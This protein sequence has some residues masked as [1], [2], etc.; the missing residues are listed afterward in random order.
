M[1]YPGQKGNVMNHRAKKVLA[2]TNYI[3]LPLLVVLLL[4]TGMLRTGQG[5]PPPEEEET[6]PEAVKRAQAGDETSFATLYQWYYRRIYYYLL[7]MVGN[8]E[9]AFD[10][11]AVT[12]AKA[13]QHIAGILDGRR[14]S[15]WLYSIATRTALD[16]L[17][18]R[19]R[20]QV[21]WGSTD[22]DSSDEHAFRFEIGIEEYELVQLALAQVAPK[23]RACLLLQLEGFSQ[24]EIATLMG[25]RKK[26]VSTYVYMAREQLRRAYRQIQNW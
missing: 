15:G 17:R 5:G 14:F 12:F 8:R 1:S 20:E 3:V 18:L 21:F 19:K 9:D 25:L 7:R 23:P 16:H 22:E 2:R 26:S 13:W 4:A 6:I 10:L 11:A 24:A